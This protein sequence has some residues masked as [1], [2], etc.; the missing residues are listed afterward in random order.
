MLAVKLKGTVHRFFWL[1]K[2]GR[3]VGQLSIYYISWPGPRVKG[4]IDDKL[5]I[6]PFFPG[7]L[8]IKY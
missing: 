3:F 7:C 5:I 1:D 6:F 8:G 2:I 4:G